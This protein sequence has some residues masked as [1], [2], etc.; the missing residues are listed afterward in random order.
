MPARLLFVLQHA[1]VLLAKR[2]TLPCALL[3]VFFSLQPS[4][5]SLP[6]APPDDAPVLPLA[7]LRPGPTGEVWTVFQ[8][9]T[10]EPFAVEV[11]GVIRNALGPGKSLILCRLTDPRV[12]H[13]GAV[14]GMSGSPLYIDG[15]FAGALSYQVQRFE[16]VRHAGFTPAADLIEVSR[17]AQSS[18]GLQPASSRGTGLRSTGFQPVDGEAA[19]SSGTGFQPVRIEWHGRPA[20]ATAPRAAM[21][22]ASKRTG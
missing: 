4:A 7:D 10:P 21:S 2:P 9:D 13:M 8:G 11:T 12:Q 14:A 19:G 18:T 22:N 15:K 3:A 5:L 20:H 16:T 17:F 1:A 6:P